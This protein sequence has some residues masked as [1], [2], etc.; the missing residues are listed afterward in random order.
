MS[1]SDESLG[2]GRTDDVDRLRLVERSMWNW[3][4]LRLGQLQGQQQRAAILVATCGILLGFAVS[5]ERNVTGAP[6]IE[7]R[8]ATGLLILA[9]VLAAAAL[10]PR[11]LGLR[12]PLRP[13]ADLT[14]DQGSPLLT[15]YFETE[16]TE[17][18]RQFASAEYEFLCGP[19]RQIY[20]RR[21]I[22]LGVQFGVVLIAAALV[23]LG[24][25][26]A[27]ATDQPTPPRRTCADRGGGEARAGQLTAVPAIGLE[28]V[29]E[30]FGAASRPRCRPS[31]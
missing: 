25:M 3:A 7:L 11:R 18:L 26:T 30:G 4:G 17:M 28:P 5:L 8:L 19:W 12:L 6:L 29:T 31:G 16:E 27:T 10:W 2:P 15:D 9:L 1:S 23:A 20:N 13:F 21:R 14:S 24:G 22:A